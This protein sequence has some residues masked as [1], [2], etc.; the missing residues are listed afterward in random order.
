MRRVQ[1][2]GVDTLEFSAHEIDPSALVFGELGCL[3]HDDVGHIGS[4]GLVEP[5]IVPPLH[6]DQIAEPLVSKFVQ[7]C[8]CERQLL[9]ECHGL[10]ASKHCLG[11]SHARNILHGAH[12]ELWHK[13]LVV[14]V[15]LVLDAEQVLVEAHTNECSRE[16]L[17]EHF[18]LNGFDHA[19]SEVHSHWRQ[20]C[21]ILLLFNVGIWAGHDREQIWRNLS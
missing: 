11:V 8:I 6:G 12:V 18:W 15:E 16:Q 20:A 17:I 2:I 14:L 5:Q 9:I 1:N 21:L 3:C 4:E 13:Y 10:S 19:F 7:D